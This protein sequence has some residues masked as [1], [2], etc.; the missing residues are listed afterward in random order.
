[1]MTRKIL[2]NWA[3]WIILDVVYVWMFFALKSLHFTAFQYAVFLLLA[4]LGLR[5]WKR[6]HDAR[7]ALAT[8]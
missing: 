4:M 6:S 5:D 8:A 2:E 3:L 7:S 1:M